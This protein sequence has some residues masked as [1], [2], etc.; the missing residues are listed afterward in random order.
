[1]MK[2][3]FP[4]INAVIAV[5][6]GMIVL[7]G[8]FITNVPALTF[9]RDLLLKW[10]VLLA[11]IAVVIGVGN[12]FAVHLQK[13][14]QRKTGAIYS[15]VLLIFFMITFL[16]VLAVHYAPAL[17]AYPG[18]LDA[19]NFFLNGIMVPVEISLMALLTV[20]LLYSSVRMLR[21][22]IDLKAILFLVAALL[23]LIS[24]APLTLDIP[25]LGDLIQLIST[26]GARGILIGVALGTLTT[27][28]RI[29]LS[30][31]RPYGG[32]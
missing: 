15:L 20:T 7:A 32:K 24:T 31:D 29:L 16:L 30:A 3:I 26:G 28:L 10:S 19:Q 27:G 4:V 13:I 21:W 12:L 23:A 9:F 1:M 22:R 8:Y 6:A 11:G 18:L 17:D 25:V 2:R 5:A 14:T